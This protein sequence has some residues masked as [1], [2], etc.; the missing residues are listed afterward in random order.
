MAVR[1][2]PRRAVRHRA[3]HASKGGPG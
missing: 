1:F 3:V 2:S